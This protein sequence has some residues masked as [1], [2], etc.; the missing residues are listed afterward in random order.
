[1]PPVFFF[2]LYHIFPARWDIGRNPKNTAC[3]LGIL[4]KKLYFTDYN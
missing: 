2:L 1:M 4:P 3:Y